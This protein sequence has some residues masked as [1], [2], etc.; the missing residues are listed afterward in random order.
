MND[1]YGHARHRN[2]IVH[3]Q[4]PTALPSSTTKTGRFDTRRLTILDRLARG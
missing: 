3:V 4:M 1:P 2:K